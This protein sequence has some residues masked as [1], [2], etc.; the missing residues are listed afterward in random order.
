MMQSTEQSAAADSAS[1]GSVAASSSSSSSDA[2]AAEARRQGRV[3]DFFIVGQPK[4]GTTALYRMLKGHPQ[5][6]MPD[7]KEPWYFASDLHSQIP[8]KPPKTLEGYLSLFAQASP[9]QRVGEAT[10]SYL[11]S[12]VAAARIAEAQPAARIIA[13][14]REPASFVRSLH[15]QFLQSHIETEKDLHKVLSLEDDR[16]HG[17]RI[18]HASRPPQ[19]YLY[20][21]RVR[22]VEQLRRYH[23]VFPAEQVLVLIYDDF[24]ADNEDTVRQVLRFLDVDDSSPIEVLE[25]NPTVSLRSRRLNDLVHTVSVGRGP[26]ARTVK[27]G[28]KA[29]TPS[30]LRRGALRATVQGVV[31]GAP[32]PPDESVMR[33]LRHRFAP[34]VVALSEYLGLDLVTRWGYDRVD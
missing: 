21:D 24:R 30:R 2:V 20:S 14:L 22:Y 8:G 13:V 16:R 1:A 15:L 6:F 23:E 12:S 4:S 29:L 5:I 31:Y 11:R 17:R 18:P 28:V 26:A 7:V 3:P 19:A 27:A 33:E 10:Q 9:D 34:E 25:A 32:D